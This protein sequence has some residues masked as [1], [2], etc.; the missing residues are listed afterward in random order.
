MIPAGDLYFFH[1][2]VDFSLSFLAIGIRKIFF[3]SIHGLAF[4][5]KYFYCLCGQKKVGFD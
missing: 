3:H 5:G 4:W 2:M 1:G